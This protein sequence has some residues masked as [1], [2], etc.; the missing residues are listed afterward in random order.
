MIRGKRRRLPVISISKLIP[1]MITVMALC[2]GLSGVRFA[3]NEQWSLAVGAIA[4]AA[5]LDTL[6]GSMA[7]LLKGQSK[8]GAELDSLGDFISFGV[9]PA[10]ILFLWST[11]DLKSF[12]WM[13]ALFFSTCMA[14][15]LARFN[16]KA[17][18]P[19]LPPFTYRFFTGVP[20]PAAAGLGLLPLILSFEAD[21]AFLHQPHFLA[22]WQV[23]VG[24]LM[25]SQVP[26]YSFKGA[27]V[28]QKLVLP[29]LIVFGICVAWLVSAPWQ[30]FAAL[31]FSY[32]VSLPFS[33]RSYLRLQRT[34]EPESETA[35][36][37]SDPDGKVTP[38][39][40]AKGEN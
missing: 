31:L 1:N 12:G 4:V 18:D 5:I 19:T 23:V 38:F 20:A 16:T 17:D 6:D 33:Y 9:S 32:L 30:F 36:E 40:K 27:R 22:V 13:A 25:V 14:L 15:R 28:P 11:H 26:T 8:F 24:L 3:L 21:F 39:G 34:V 2:A 10:L 7:R 29:L 37:T 35:D